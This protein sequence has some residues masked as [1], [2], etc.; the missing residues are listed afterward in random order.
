M[1]KAF[2]YLLVFSFILSALTG[3]SVGAQR[4]SDAVTG[5]IASADLF[6]ENTKNIIFAPG[7]EQFSY[8]FTWEAVS[9]NAEYLQYTKAVN[10]NSGAM[11]ENANK[12]Q[13]NIT[14]TGRG[15]TARAYIKGLSDDTEYC[16]RVG[17][18]SAGWS[19]IYTFKTSDQDGAF[20]FILSGDP[21][22]G[23]SGS[24]SVDTVNWNN[25][26]NNA[27]KWFGDEI[28]FLMT[29]GD[30]VNS[31]TKHVQYEGFMSNS[32]LRSIPTVTTVGNH[33]NGTNY[34]DYYTYSNVDQT[35]LTSGGVYGGDYW[36][37]YDS[38]LIMSLNFNNTS[39]ATHK[40]FMEKA[41]NN[42]TTYYGEPTWTIAVFH[43]P[44]YSQGVRAEY[45]FTV[46][47]RNEL[48]PVLSELGVDVVLTGHDHV[49]TR[50]YM[51]N[52]T[53]VK[54]DSGI[55]TAVNG[56]S[57]GSIYDPADGDVFYLTVNSGSGS[58]YY[59][60]NSNVMPFTCVS[61]KE[62]VQTLTKV[63]VTWDS[64]SFTTHRI[65]ENNSMNDVFDF[66]AIHRST[67]EDYYAPTLSVEPETYFDINE[68]FDPLDGVSA[69]DNV[70]GDISHKITYTGEIDNKNE[71]V[72]TYTVSDSMGNT[73]QKTRKM[74]PYSYTE[75]VSSEVA[76]KYIDDGST[77]YSGSD[78]T[79]WATNSFDD[80]SW[81]TGYSPFGA[82]AGALSKHNSY[83]AKTLLTQYY[84]EGHE[85]AGNNIPNYYFRTEFDLT[86]PEFIQYLKGSVRYDD[87]CEVFIN[88]VK[89]ASF[90]CA[91][92]SNGAG[93]CSKTSS[94]GAD[95]GEFN[96]TD[97]NI[98]K[99][100]NLKEKGNVLAVSLFQS[101]ATS[102]DI[103]FKFCGI[104]FSKTD[105]YHYD[106]KE[107]VGEDVTW[108]F[109]DDGTTPYNGNDITT[110]ATSDYDSSAWNKGVSGF[111][112]K[113]GQ[114]GSHNGIKAKT[115]L[116][117]SYPTG[118]ANEGNAIPNYFFR[119]SF[120]LE[121]PELVSVLSGEFLF[122]DA[123]SV[124][125]NGVKVANYNTEK[126]K[127]GAGYSNMLASFNA[128]EGRFII[129]GDLVASLGLKEK[130]NVIAV[131]LHQSNA[132][133]SDVFFKFN[134]MKAGERAAE[135][136][137]TSNGVTLNMHELQ[138]VRDIFIA[139]G[140]WNSYREVK[141]NL[142]VMLTQN[143][144][145]GNNSYTYILPNPGAYTVYIRY[146]NTNIADKV[147]KTV[148]TATEPAFLANGLQLTIDNLEGV[149]VVR[150]AYGEY[151]SAG[152]IKRAPGSRSFSARDIN[153]SEYMIQYRENGRISVAVCYQNGYNV[154]YHYDIAK[155]TPEFI[156]NA[157]T[158]TFSSLNDLKVIRY[159]K[160]EYTTSTQIKNAPGA[161]SVQGYKIEGDSYTV[162]LTPGVYTFCVQYNDES[163][164]Y[165]TVTIE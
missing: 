116:N 8:N 4:Q 23:A 42:Y 84:P 146:N 11:P 115:L 126:I 21:Q 154:I 92:V 59:N 96:L 158:V 91:K 148:L 43:Q 57:Y 134:G 105:P 121:S 141:D 1:K 68:G 67:D 142:V 122:D 133:S 117:Y 72:L 145:A 89:I 10:L 40:A 63:D 123:C 33:D 48:A 140:D 143:K 106:M 119:H 31:S 132:T 80:S 162:T 165:Y 111:G 78:I 61:S 95:L 114:L 17:S 104:K 98:I 44:I 164:N 94:N 19:Q 136:Y 161:I 82:K 27:H 149:K 76:W 152:E 144:L 81:K 32:W 34:S 107:V 39:I 49:Y 131:V 25:T 87:A 160:G 130:G 16:Y 85:S 60:L 138:G 129:C 112:S 75:E 103:F 36:F 71:F 55:Y 56:D 150:T 18:D 97:I 13:A 77:P 156:Q 153:G 58:K 90:N 113:S 151:K 45:E 86:N 100:L 38:A 29:A 155:K 83:R 14:S 163:Y 66:F 2:S 127:N 64:I 26:L 47:Q 62:N 24:N 3:F 147:L 7:T 102:S 125:I 41:I 118:H 109:L 139:K 70:E 28:E 46:A 99:S 159:A 93:Y 124:F 108:D 20:S 30:Q 157:N 15:Y 135:P 128:D 137:L 73:T 37:A 101:D 69:Y 35:T 53:T 65:S 88:G 79:S 50:A 51:M 52:G 12:V 5:E 22:I 120:D 74:I 54:D 9:L 110:W 6:G